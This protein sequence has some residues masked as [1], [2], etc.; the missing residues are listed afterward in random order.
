VRRPPCWITLTDIGTSRGRRAGGAMSSAPALPPVP[1]RIGSATAADEVATTTASTSGR[2]GPTSA[3]ANP[4]GTAI[5]FICELDP[6]LRELAILQVGCVV[7]NAHE[8]S[9]HVE[10]GHD[11]GV[12][13]DDVHVLI[14]DT[15]GRPTT[16]GS[17][18]A[19]CSPQPRR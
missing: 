4:A 11:L 14:A 8:F 5:R 16:S 9:H 15:A 17:S 18:T 10:L 7:G 1:C 12:S 3:S 13:D 19:S 6:R 2:S